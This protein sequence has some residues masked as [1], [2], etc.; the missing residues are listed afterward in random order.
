MNHQ[1]W[2]PE[3]DCQTTK[4]K[5]PLEERE[6]PKSFPWNF[7]YDKEAFQISEKD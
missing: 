2:I 1:K 5:I 3:D 6:L 4:I 7:L